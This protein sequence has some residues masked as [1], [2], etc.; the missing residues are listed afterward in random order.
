MALRHGGRS[1]EHCRKDGPIDLI[2]RITG[3]GEAARDQ[4][5]PDRVRHDDGFLGG[6]PHRV[7][8]CSVGDDG[9]LPVRGRRDVSSDFQQWRR[10][11]FGGIGL[12][13]IPR[14]DHAAA[15]AF[16]R[17]RALCGWR[18]RAL[19]QGPR[20]DA[21]PRGPVDQL[22]NRVMRGRYLPRRKL[23]FA[24]FAGRCGSVKGKKVVHLAVS[25]HG[26][27]RLDTLGPAP[28]CLALPQLHERRK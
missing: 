2:A 5:R 19:G 13:R 14:R 16:S 21:H 9:V 3:S 27:R 22:R 20:R 18:G 8:R 1:D 15:G 4:G 17:W 11:G 12:R 25:L 28:T 24:F 6:L 10:G 26:R 23:P 7:R